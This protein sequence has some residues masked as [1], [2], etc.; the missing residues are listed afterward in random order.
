MKKINSYDE[1]IKHKKEIEKNKRSELNKIII[2]ISL[3]TCGIAAG[4]SHIKDYIIKRLEE[5]NIKEYIIKDVGCMGYCYL[6]PTIEITLPGYQPVVYGNVDE[7]KIDEIIEKYLINHEIV[8]GI[9]PINY[10]TI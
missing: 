5:E 6:E 10:E 2:K 3:A 8:D 7:H 4:G 1:L 9:I